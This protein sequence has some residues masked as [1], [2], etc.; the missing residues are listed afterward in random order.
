MSEGPASLQPVL[1]TLID[2]LFPRSC[3]GCRTGPWPFC[4][5]CWASMA[6]F[7][8]PG[9]RRCG[10]P[11]P[12][13]VYRCADCPPAELDWVR[14]AF[15]YE[16]RRAGFR[17]WQAIEKL[18]TDKG[19]E[20]ELARVTERANREIIDYSRL[21]PHEREIIRRVIFFYP[22]VKGSTV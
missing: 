2:V 19:H 22:W 6:L 5:R 10:R 7:D 8:A 14:S 18:L 11:L 15:L 21:G 1:D 13:E 20:A 12:V 16:A 17:D 9:C 3:L 4:P